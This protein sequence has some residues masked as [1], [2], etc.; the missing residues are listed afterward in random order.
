MQTEAVESLKIDHETPVLGT[1]GYGRG[2]TPSFE[3]K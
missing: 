3:W 2:R 1:G